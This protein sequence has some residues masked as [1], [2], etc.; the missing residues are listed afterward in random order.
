MTTENDI[1][2]FDP[3]SLSVFNQ[4][5]TPKS[6]GNSLIYKTKPAD[7]KSEDKVYRATIKVVYNPFDPKHSILD[8]QSYAIQDAEGWLTVVSSLT[9]GDTSCPIFK[10]WK[11]CHYADP[12]KDEASKKLW[13]QAAKKEDGGNELFDKRFAR[14]CVVQILEDN[15]QPDLVGKFMFWKLPKSVMDIIMAKMNP[16]PES[17][18]PAIPVMDFLFGR[19]IDIEVTPGPGQPGDERYARETKYM[20]EL[21]EDVVSC[22][23]PDGSPILNDEEQAVLDNYVEAMKEVWKEKDP[24]VRASKKAAVD[25]DPN[26]AALGKIYNNKVIPTIKSVCPNLIEELGYKPWSDNVKARVQK[27]IDIVLAGNDPKIADAAPEIANT[28]GTTTETKVEAPVS[29]AT[30]T[31]APTVEEDPASDLPF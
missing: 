22:I 26:T 25:Q 7:S 8:Q 13:L 10:A 12:K 19:S 31:T 5:E 28:I 3:Q 27:W 30:V 9:I 24:E 4:D 20:A 2:G 6:Q 16:S 21:S 18:K 17:K 29:T 11:R 23:N 14:Y 1:L 15:N